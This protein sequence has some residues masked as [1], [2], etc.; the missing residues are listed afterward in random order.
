LKSKDEQFLKIL[1]AKSIKLLSINN[2]KR[3]L[4]RAE[5]K[6]ERG[7]YKNFRA[8]T[9]A[10]TEKKVQIPDTKDG[11][12]GAAR[13]AERKPPG[14]K[15]EKLLRVEKTESICQCGQPPKNATRRKTRRTSTLFENVDSKKIS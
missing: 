15:R 5:K 10:P 13:M 2:L 9:C 6:G 11:R 1:G 4:H 12:Y 3:A 7:V 14:E 8:N